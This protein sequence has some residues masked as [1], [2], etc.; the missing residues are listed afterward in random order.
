MLHKYSNAVDSHQPLM[1]LR[2]KAD[3]LSNEYTCAVVCGLGQIAGNE[4]KAFFARLSQLEHQLITL[5]KNFNLVPAL[6][7]HCIA[8]QK[9]LLEIKLA[10]ANIVSHMSKISERLHK[11]QSGIIDSEGV[12]VRLVKALLQAS[13]GKLTIDRKHVT[14][15]AANGSKQA[16][17]MD[18]PTKAA[19]KSLFE[20]TNIYDTLQLIAGNSDEIIVAHFSVKFDGDS[21]SSINITIGDRKHE[22]NTITFNPVRMFLPQTQVITISSLQL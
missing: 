1:K 7:L 15:K 6:S 19:V 11:S 13:S 17:V 20:N 9:N 14:V 22:N 21:P 10:Q 8:A 3:E 16:F 18:E 12:K 4:E 2:G 5:Q